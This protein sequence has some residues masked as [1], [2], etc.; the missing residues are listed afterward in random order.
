MIMKK[1]VFFFNIFIKYFPLKITEI[2]DE[3]WN[4]GSIGYFNILELST[5]NHTN[6][7]SVSFLDFIIFLLI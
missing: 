2:Q 6:L 5:L 4:Y 3:L 1:I 7:V